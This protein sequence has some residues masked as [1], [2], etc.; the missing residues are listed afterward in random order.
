MKKQTK[1]LLETRKINEVITN[2]MDGFVT[3]LDELQVKA[4]VMYDEEVITA[5]QYYHILSTLV[6]A[7]KFYKAQLIEYSSICDQCITA[8]TRDVTEEVLEEYEDEEDQA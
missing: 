4:R 1:Q 3:E 8:I 7:R 2:T 5:G 6:E